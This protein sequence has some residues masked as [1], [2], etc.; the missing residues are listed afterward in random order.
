MTAAYFADAQYEPPTLLRRSETG[1]EA[2]RN[3]AWVPTKT[4]VDWEFGNN[5]FVDKVTEA[6]ARALTPAAFI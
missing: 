3:G 4:I 6:D 2:F 5:D 1:D